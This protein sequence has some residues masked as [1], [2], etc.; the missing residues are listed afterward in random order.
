MTPLVGITVCIDRGQRLRAGADYL[1]VRRA[2][3]EQVRR[4]GAEPLLL[5]P[6][7]SPQRAATSCD[8]FLITGGDDLPVSF[9]AGA[10]D[11]PEH[12]EDAERIAWE[13]ALL[14]AVS[15]LAKPVLGVCYGMQ[16]INLFCGGTLYRSLGDEHPGGVDHGGGSSTTRHALSHVEASP[17]LRGLHAGLV[18]NSCH[19]QAVRAVAPGF[20]VTA[21]AGDGIVEAME[22]APFYAVEWHPETDPASHGVYDNFVALVREAAAVKAGGA[23]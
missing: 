22:R 1:Y 17:L 18:V 8:A 2:Y 21:L 23:P 16:L 14:A 15:A 6:D 4:A 19:R 20:R 3:A 11:A 12:A 9:E 7:T 13:R 10:R 5:T